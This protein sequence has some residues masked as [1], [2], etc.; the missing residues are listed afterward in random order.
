VACFFWLKNRQK[1]IWREKVQVSNDPDNPVSI[2]LNMAG[3]P[4]KRK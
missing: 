1:D 3:D 2:V 4:A